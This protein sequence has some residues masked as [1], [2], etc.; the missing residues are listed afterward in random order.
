MLTFS[1]SF[2][3]ATVDYSLKGR[4]TAR[5]FGLAVRQSDEPPEKTGIVNI[6]EDCDTFLFSAPPLI[7][8]RRHAMLSSVLPDDAAFPVRLRCARAG[9][10]C[11]FP[12]LLPGMLVREP[13]HGMQALL[14]RQRIKE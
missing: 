13:V 3:A 2:F 9:M 7:G 12:V 11:G 4:G 6:H 5:A 10:I 1:R 14:E 8:P